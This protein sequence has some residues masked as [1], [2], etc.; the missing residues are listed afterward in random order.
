MKVVIDT[1]VL[2]VANRQHEGASP[3]CE[4]ACMNALDQARKGLV[5]LDED[6]KIL[7]EYANR[8]SHAGQPGVGDAFFKWLW[9]NQA[10]PK[11]CQKVRITPDP[12]REFAEFPDDPDLS[13]FDRKDRKFVAVALASGLDPEVLNATDK[14]WYYY[15]AALKRNGVRVRFLCPDAMPEPS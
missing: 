15:S 10:N 12:N 6:G 11:H 7:D 3:D 8:C 5:L 2:V 9:D 13:G 1:N 4:E 14:G